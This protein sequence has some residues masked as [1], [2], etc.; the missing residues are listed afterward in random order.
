V[1][2]FSPL[3]KTAIVVII[4]AGV[5]VNAGIMMHSYFQARNT[6]YSRVN[7]IRNAK[8][9]CL[10]CKDYAGAHGG[11][12]PLTL[13]ALFPQYLTDRS[14]LVSPFKPGEPD[15]YIYT[16]PGPGKA[17]SAETI[18]IEDK[19]ASTDATIGNIRIVAYANGDG[20]V[21]SNP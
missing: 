4:I 9:I 5:A 12:Y 11:S 19:F 15:G 14:V 8:Q 2:S 18:V 10:A 6:L 17:G 3:R 13:D 7:S 16:P 20:R 1:T 21:L